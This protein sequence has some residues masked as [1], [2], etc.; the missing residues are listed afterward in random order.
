MSKTEVSLDEIKRVRDEFFEKIRT[1]LNTNDKK[2][3]MGFVDNNPDW[4]LVR[5]NK[6]K[7]YP[8]IKWKMLN[9]EKMSKEKREKYIKNLK[10]FFQMI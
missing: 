6:I 3:L 1:I 5:D 9:Q 8:S 7:N 4:S 10:T 2:F